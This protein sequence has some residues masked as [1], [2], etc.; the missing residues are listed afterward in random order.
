M[1][2]GS[3][4]ICAFSGWFGCR[5]GMILS[6]VP[7]MVILGCSRIRAVSRFSSAIL[8]DLAMRGFAISILR[9]ARVASPGLFFAF[10]AFLRSIR[11]P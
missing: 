10:V 5:D 3:T 8:P 4:A 9:L 11:P 7:E 6:T 1:P 2:V